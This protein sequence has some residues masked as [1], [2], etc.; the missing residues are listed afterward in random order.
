MDFKHD[1]QTPSL[2]REEAYILG[3]L[4]DTPMNKVEHKDK[5]LILTIRDSIFPKNTIITSIKGNLKTYK[6]YTDPKYYDFNN[7]FL[8]L[9]NTN[10]YDFIRGIFDVSGN[11]NKQTTECSLVCK[12]NIVYEEIKDYITMKNL[13]LRFL[14]ENE[15][16]NVINKFIFKGCNATD[17]LSKIYDNSN[18]FFRLKS[19]YKT[20][21]RYLG[22]SGPGKAFSE[23]RVPVVKFKKTDPIA[24]APHKKNSSDEGYDLWL[25]KVDKKISEY[26]VQ[27]NTCIQVQPE[28][29]WHIELL[30][31]SS[32]SD[33]GWSLSNSVGLIDNPYRGN[34]K[35]RLTKTDLDVKDLV[36]PFKACQMVLRKNIHYLCQEVQELDDTERGS[37]GFGSTNRTQPPPI[38]SVVLPPVLE[39][40]ILS[41]IDE[42]V[43]PAIAEKEL[44]LDTWNNIKDAWVNQSLDKLNNIFEENDRALKRSGIP[45]HL[46]SLQGRLEIFNTSISGKD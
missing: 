23:G 26:T 1:P 34:L 30:A 19:N 36:L 27:F 28:D 37:G 18:P 3:W 16:D 43:K 22:H 17:F 44:D 46:Q 11:M 29:G 45:E 14:D 38:E 24:I 20:Y 9:D 6:F 33:Y 21:I 39:D 32:L 40:S 2:S 10:M 25:V 41:A 7:K 12:T 4:S 15:I 35:V 5:N 31:R 13:H 8:L 42:T